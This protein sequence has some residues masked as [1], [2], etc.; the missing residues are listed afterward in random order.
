V[1]SEE[2]LNWFQKLIEILKAII[3]LPPPRGGV[4]EVE[5]TDSPRPK[6]PPPPPPPPPKEIKV[7]VETKEEPKKDIMEKQ[8]L[9]KLDKSLEQK[10][11][12]EYL[13][14]IE[15]G[16]KKRVMAKQLKNQPIRLFEQWLA[17]D[18]FDVVIGDKLKSLIPNDTRAWEGVVGHHS[19][20]ADGKVVDEE[21]I[22]RYHTSWRRWGNI[23]TKQEADRLIA[24]GEEGVEAPWSDNGYNILVEFTG[25]DTVSIFLARPLSKTGGHCKQN[26]RNRTHLGLC[27]VGNFDAIEPSP[28]KLAVGASVIKAYRDYYAF[29]NENVEPHRRWADY[30]TCPGRRFDWDHFKEVYL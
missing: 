17:M 23:I 10:K 27:W 4:T 26:H 11:E 29:K 18:D 30:K 2:K 28:L 24:A 7:T 5:R 15:W 14:R 12:K 21:G 19:L 13:I 25:D 9:I 20:T 1:G 22:T 8:P 6:P 16:G 3:K